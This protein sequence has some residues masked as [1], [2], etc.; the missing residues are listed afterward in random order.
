MK[1]YETNLTFSGMT[2]HAVI[3]EFDRN[4][5]MLFWSKGQYVGCWDLGGDVWFTS[6]WL[7]TNSPENNHCY[8]PIMDKKLKYSR[9]E[10]LE[11]NDARTKI[12]WRYA[13]NDLR[14]RIFHGNTFAE[15]IF[16]V[17]PD[18]IAVRQVTAY[19]GDESGFGGNPNFWQIIEWIV[20]H[21]TKTHP[22][23]SLQK[24]PAFSFFNDQGDSVALEYPIQF[25]NFQPLCH[26]FPQIKDWEMYIGYVHLVERPNP[27]V[28]LAKDQ[29]LFPYR[30]CSH[31]G[32]DHP[33]FSLFS[34]TGCTWKISIRQ[35][36]FHTF[37]KWS[38]RD[39][40]P[41]GEYVIHRWQL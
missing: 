6:E 7:E 11:S 14:Y 25:E 30:R 32:G 12:R 39:R 35:R 5:R 22:E 33:Y 17:Y 31:C 1:V 26:A 2:G 40:Q 15:E 21:G 18:G 3:V 37:R 9:V 19:P 10:V 16:T 41:G 34:K 29:R 13:C 27:F 36:R 28:V 24:N 23:R 4:Y 38:G 8:E 20:I